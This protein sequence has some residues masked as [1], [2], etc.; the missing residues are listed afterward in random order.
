MRRRR[1]PGT[2]RLA[3]RIEGENMKF[4]TTQEASNRVVI[5]ASRM[6]LQK[7]DDTKS[8]QEQNLKGFHGEAMDTIEHPHPYGFAA[9]AKAPSADGSAEAFVNFLGGNRSHGVVLV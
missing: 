3:N 2:V 8:M 4:A 9:L 7:A 5:A 1:V 6:K